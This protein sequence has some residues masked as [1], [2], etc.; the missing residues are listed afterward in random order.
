MYLC[1]YQ[2][3]K[4]LLTTL[5]IILL[6]H[7]LIFS[8]TLTDRDYDA[9]D[10]VEDRLFDL[11]EDKWRDADYVVWAIQL[12]MSNKKLDEKRNTLLIQL[13]DD[14]DYYRYSDE[15]GAIEWYM[16]PQDCYE[17]EFYDTD[18]ERCYPNE[19]VDIDYHEEHSGSESSDDLPILAAYLLL[20]DDTLNLVD[21]DADPLHQ[22]VWNLFSSMIPAA[23]RPDLVSVNFANNPNSDTAAYVEQTNEHHEKWR[24]VFNLDSYYQVGELIKEEAIHTNIHEFAHILT[25]QKSQAQ[26]FN[27]MTDEASVARYEK[28]CTTYFLQEWCLL[29]TSYFKGYI[30]AFWDK[31]ELQQA[32]EDWEPDTYTAE[33]YVSDYATTNPGEDIAES[34]TMFVLKTKPAGTTE[35]EEKIAYFYQYPEL[36][37][38]RSFIRSR[39]K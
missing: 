30:D 31:N 21:G 2:N 23:A 6:S 34:F 14:I 20:E 32:R 12:F 4:K 17:D 25:L 3:M 19:E 28:E 37:K 36:V 1:I 27:P 11:M 5:L 33:E 24:I 35:A 38:L 15:E 7:W 39:S 8:Y 26:L 16:S 29:R 22:E 13:I 9:L 18:E 10:I